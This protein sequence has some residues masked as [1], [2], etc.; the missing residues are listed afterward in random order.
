M[1][2]SMR[3]RRWLLVVLVSLLLSAP[4]AAELTPEQTTELRPV[5]EKQVESPQKEVR[6]LAVL[7]LGEMLADKKEVKSFYIYLENPDTVIK[8]AAVLAL[9]QRGDKKGLKAL[10]AAL[11]VEDAST[12]PASLSGLLQPLDADARRKILKSILKK[13]PSD[14]HRIAYVR[15]I[16]EFGDAAD[17]KLLEGVVKIKSPEARAGVI[18]TLKK[19]PRAEALVVARALTK[20]KDSATRV[21]NLELARVIDTTESRQVIVDALKDKE[22]PVKQAAEKHL[23]EL[24]HPSVIP[25]LK[26]RVVADPNDKDALK[27]LLAF[28]G[29]DLVA[30]LK[31]L[32]A[33][34]NPKLEQA[35]YNQIM[36]VIARSKSQEAT[37]LINARLKSSYT[38]DR[39]A[40]THAIR[41]TE[42]R[43]FT[44]IVN[45]LIFDGSPLVRAE[46]AQAFAALKDPA[47]LETINKALNGNY[48]T[49]I[50]V[51]LLRAIGAIG[52]KSA[53]KYL[54]FHVMSQDTPIRIAAIDAIVSLKARDMTSAVE[55]ASGDGDAEIAWRATVGLFLIDPAVYA[56]PL[57][58][59]MPEAPEKAFF[60][61]LDRLDDATRQ[62]LIEQ[63]LRSRRR[64][65]ALKLIAAAA[66]K[67]SPDDL[68]VLR[69]A[70]D[71]SPI[72]QVRREVLTTLSRHTF[73]E[74]LD[75]FK[76]M[77]EHPNRPVRLMA[78]SAL[79]RYEPAKAQEVFTKASTD[80]DPLIQTMGIYG[81]A[82]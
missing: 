54:Q 68:E 78:L 76:K 24:H 70:F 59:A 72:E 40:A 7:T 41:F 6:R 81:L 28:D 79:L 63:A 74:D 4:A 5:V 18:D 75:R 77:S 12:L 51:D 56:K 11:K 20:A 23:I 48:S 21:K 62:K 49:T 46:A 1:V 9:A 69:F 65:I 15:F 10:E 3:S 82:R 52:D 80:A 37:E 26:A 16:T 30:A 67:L 29:V 27:H 55:L 35:D 2:S 64:D 66:A 53:A 34:E 61:T 73:A 47:S 17:F 71:N 43:V 22:E 13:P 32:V 57:T 44:P 8:E 58:K 33:K 25:T 19:K 42:D 14:A 36:G 60:S 45:R 38:P 31:P 39:V 50:K